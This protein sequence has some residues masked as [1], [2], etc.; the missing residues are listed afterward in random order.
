MTDQSTRQFPTHH[1]AFQYGKFY[2]YDPASRTMRNRDMLPVF[3]FWLVIMPIGIIGNLYSL[4]TEAGPWWPGKLLS[5]AVFIVLLL[6][7]YYLVLWIKAPH[8]NEYPEIQ[9]LESGLR[10]RVFE[11]YLVW[12]FVPW[13][14]IEAVVRSPLSDELIGTVWCIQLQHLTRWHCRLG[15]TWLQD[16]RPVIVLSA[17]FPDRQELLDTIQAHIGA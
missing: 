1:N 13:A 5:F 12:R 16:P 6:G 7:I 2:A 15:W 10:V 9:V 4:L 3:I 11:W 17:T 14:E 8:I